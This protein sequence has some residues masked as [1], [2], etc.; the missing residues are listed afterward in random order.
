MGVTILIIFV[1]FGVLFLLVGQIDYL[2][3]EYPKRLHKK[4]FVTFG[5]YEKKRHRNRIS[6]VTL[7]LTPL[8]VGWKE[9]SFVHVNEFACKIH[10]KE[11]KVKVDESE[12]NFADYFTIDFKDNLVE[13]TASESGFFDIDHITLDE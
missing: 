1:A 8:A 7:E 6:F 9:E 13:I 11:C 4:L 12:K 2:E 5:K 3:F 10:C